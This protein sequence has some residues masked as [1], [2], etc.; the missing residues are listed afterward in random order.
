M[1]K[2]KSYTCSKC[3]GVLMFDSD[4][5]FFECPFCGTAFNVVDFHA[6]ELLKQADECLAQSDFNTAKD[7]YGKI[8][9]NEPDNCRALLGMVLCEAR[10]SS[11]E[12]LKDPDF[13]TRCDIRGVRT[14]VDTAVKRAP[15]QA[16]PLFEKIA[17]LVSLEEELVPL[18]E[19]LKIVNKEITPE[20][21]KLSHAIVD[22]EQRSITNTIIMAGVAFAV[23]AGMIIIAFGADGWESGNWPVLIGLI[24][25]IGLIIGGFVILTLCVDNKNK[26]VFATHNIVVNAKNESYETKAKADGIRA[27]YADEYAGLPELK[28]KAETA[29][30]TASKAPV[31]PSGALLDASI[32]ENSDKVIICEKCAARLSLNKEKRVYEC[33]SCG[34]AY[35]VSLFFGM[36]LE[37]ALN[38]MNMGLY[39]DAEMRFSNL[40]MVDPSDF[41]GLLGRI[42]CTGKWNNVSSICVSDSLRPVTYKN[43]QVMANEAAGAAGESDKGF[44][45]ELK[46]LLSL[47]EE[48]YMIDYK[49]KSAGRKIEE[50]DAKGRVFSSDEYGINA[51]NYREK[52]HVQDELQPYVSRKKDLQ[53]NFNKIKE[54]LRKMRSGSALC[55]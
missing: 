22:V 32:D 46:K 2:L 16:V 29:A 17:S 24:L 12:G 55:K 8:L 5:D 26:K 53:Y 19:E 13:Y 34:V 40:L 15:E 11:I 14:A 21:L 6:D 36:P 48:L 50:L 45:E 47:L 3:A 9:D 35:G 18:D 54:T 38:A 10:A 25:F 49:E 51:A 7:K 4:Q 42:L 37:K 41:D 1:A 27:K 23:I 43:L 28:T 31:R 33:G 39:E 20:A 30:D 44:F 52:W